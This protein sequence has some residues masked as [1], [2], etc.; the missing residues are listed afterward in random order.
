MPAIIPLGVEAAAAGGALAGAEAAAGAAAGIAGAQV[1]T[2]VAETGYS[3]YQGQQAKAQ[4]RGAESKQ[5]RAQRQV[6]ADLAAQAAQAEAE[7]TRGLAKSTQRQRA[8]AAAGRR[9]TLLTGPLG[10]PGEAQGGQRQIL[11]G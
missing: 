7:K 9:S 5:R 11:G 10:L 2:G 4:A 3:A 1:V 8:F 6:E